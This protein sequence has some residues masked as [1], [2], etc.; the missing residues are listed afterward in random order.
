M[1]RLDRL[2]PELRRVIRFALVGTANT[3][4]AL[5]SYAALI[6]L[7]VNYLIAGPVAWTLGV[8][9]GYFGNRLWTFEGAAH[10]IS[11]MSRYVAVGVLGLGMN[12][13]LLAL[14]IR[15]F[16]VGELE[17]ELV[18]LP[19]VVVTT[20]AINRYWVFGPHLREI[21]ARSGDPS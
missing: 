18:A 12:S 17:A 3:I 13:A 9:N 15:G 4:I 16:D 19:I 14:M 21:A 11:T 7:G 5:A 20:F 6:E 10:R 8:L 2:N 1:R